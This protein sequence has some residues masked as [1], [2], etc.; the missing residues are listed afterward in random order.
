[1]TDLNKLSKE[2]HENI[3]KVGWW[4]NPNLCPYQCFQMI[5]T[6]IAEATE[7][8]RRDLMDDH[9]PHRKMGEVELADAL[10]R[11]LDLGGRYGWQHLYCMPIFRQ[12]I[13]SIAGRHL[14]C[15]ANLMALAEAF[16]F[17]D[18]CNIAYSMVIDILVHTAE[19]MNYD[20]FGAL[21][22][23]LEYNKTRPDHKREQRAKKHGKKY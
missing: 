20:I 22:E 14:V 6:E 2:I 13:K 21:F 15:N 1:M 16:Y 12:K 10:I 7:G 9:L 8:E 17:N 11:V 5:S 4:D 18:D 3:V 23:K 19:W